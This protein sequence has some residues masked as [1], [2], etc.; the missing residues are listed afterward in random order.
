MHYL[1][2]APHPGRVKLL[3]AAQGV[4]QLL[5]GCL[6]TLL[7][8][9]FGSKTAIKGRRLVIVGLGKL[10]TW[11]NPVRYINEDVYKTAPSA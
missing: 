5:I 7:T 1:E 3:L 2:H 9:E 6:T 11:R 8:W 10:L 4:V